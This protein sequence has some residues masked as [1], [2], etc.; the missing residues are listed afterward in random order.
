MVDSEEIRRRVA[1]A[2]PGAEIAIRDMVGDG[3]HLE[4]IVVS[5]SFEGKTTLE[6][7]RLVY[8]PLRDLLGGA[9]H[10]L[11]LK[12]MTPAEHGRG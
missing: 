1:A 10:A 9:L 6:R 4:M 3:D 7:H 2:L 12:T 11:A 5:S 8:A